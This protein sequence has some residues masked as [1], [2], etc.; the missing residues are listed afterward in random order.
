LTEGKSWQGKTKV[1]QERGESSPEYCIKDIR[2]IQKTI[3]CSWCK[4]TPRPG[5]S[6]LGLCMIS[7][8]GSGGT[9]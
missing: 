1:E 5:D 6:W 3:L 4:I 2:S 7:H 8:Q 9:E